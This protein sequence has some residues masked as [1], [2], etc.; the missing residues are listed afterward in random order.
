MGRAFLTSL[1]LPALSVTVYLLH[2]KGSE[3][4]TRKS[5]AYWH[6][7]EVVGEVKDI[8]HRALDILA[9]GDGHGALAVLEVAT[10]EVV[11]EWTNL[12]DSDGYVG[13]LFRGLGKLWAEVL[14]STDLSQDERAGWA[15]MLTA[16]QGEIDD[17]GFDDAFD[18]AIGAALSGWGDPRSRQIG[19]TDKGEAIWDEDTPFDTEELVQIKLRILERQERF[20]EYL[21][22]ARVEHQTEAYLTMLVCLDRAQ[23]A[24]AYGRMHLAAPGEALAL[25][26]AL[27][28]HGEREE[29][30]QIAEQG[31][32]LDGRKAELAVWLRDQAESMG[33]RELALKAAEQA[34]CSHMSLEHYRSVAKL[35]GEQWDAR[36]TALLADARTAQGYETQGK[37]DVFLYEGLIDDAIAALGQY[38]GHE[39]IG[40]VVDA[41]LKERPEWV[42]QACQKQA[43]WIM[44]GGKSQYYQAAANWL[45]KAHQAYQ[46]LNRNDEWQA[47]V[48][49]LF[50]LHGRKYKLVPLL[51][52]IK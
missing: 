13:D 25:A 43:E 49:R 22:L 21:A 35:A 37:V 24:V 45:A 31:L 6:V 51:K 32:T 5:E 18:I 48:N 46:M 8:A 41:A 20:D 15:D 39:L 1:L 28:E 33:Q 11:E 7:G 19:I 47:Y 42:I 52:G 14:L 27:Y 44:N 29:S 4:I 36:K 40:K 16:W 2:D 50:Q 9:T 34:F 23:E 12:D 10:D 3:S 38:S 17:Y 26:R 30:L